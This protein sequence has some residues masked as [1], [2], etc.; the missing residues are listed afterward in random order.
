[1]CFYVVTETHT[2][3]SYQ[4][5]FPHLKLKLLLSA[6]GHGIVPLIIFACTNLHNV[7]TVHVNWIMLFLLNYC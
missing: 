5:F 6:S 7:Y 3:V 2:A 1:M 4:R